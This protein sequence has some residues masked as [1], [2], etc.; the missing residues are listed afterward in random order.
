MQHAITPVGAAAVSALI[1]GS[2]Q[3]RQERSA[4]GGQSMEEGRRRRP[5]RG[6]R[7][8]LVLQGGKRPV[9]TESGEALDSEAI[10]LEAPTLVAA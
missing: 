6:E 10:S 4:P 3:P 8:L 1:I 2:G 7:L 5:S 9:K